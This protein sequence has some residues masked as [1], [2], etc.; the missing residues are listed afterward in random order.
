MSEKKPKEN[1]KT[2][3]IILGIIALVIAIFDSLVKSYFDMA[4][5]VSWGIFFIF[6]G[7]RGWLDSRLSTKSV[8]IIHFILLVIIIMAS[9]SKLFYRLKNLSP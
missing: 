2:I 3:Y 6:L 5:S 4:L 8:K 7:M 9:F 1:I